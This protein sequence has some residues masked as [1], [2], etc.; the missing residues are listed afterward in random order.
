MDAL[1]F[2]KRIE[3][4][5]SEYGVS[6]IN[7]IR[8][9]IMCDVDVYCIDMDAT[10]FFENSKVI[11]NEF[12]NKRLSLIPIIS[13]YPDVDYDAIRIECKTKNNTQD[14]LYI[15]FSDLVF[16]DATGKPIEKPFSYFP[17]VPVTKLKPNHSI[18]FETR[19]KK[20]TS[21][22]DGAAFNPTCTCVHTFEVDKEALEAKIT[23]LGFS[24]KEANSFRLDN[25]EQYYK[26]AS[27][28]SAPG[29]YHFR[30]ESVGHFPA[31]EVYQQGIEKLRERLLRAK[32]E[33]NVKSSE[34]IVISRNKKSDEVYDLVFYDE[35]DTLGNI[36]SEYLAQEP[37][38]K[39]VGYRLSHPQKYEMLMKITLAENNNKEG[40]VK[41]Y[42]EVINKIL[43][44]L[45]TLA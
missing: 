26:R 18:S 4:P 37:D 1:I 35:N 29:A 20:S 42:I 36:L 3:N 14:A 34:K 41:K 17:T 38:V 19:L 30:I 13:N 32:A 16:K 27:N 39:Y 23:E 44:L 10:E 12:V 9:T 28:S 25:G 33:I 31:A 22:A 15:Y 2:E 45:D 11:D 21:Q 40:I 8:R 24:E 43:K 6:L 5:K 7:A